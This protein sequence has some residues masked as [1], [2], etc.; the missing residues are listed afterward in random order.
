MQLDNKPQYNN[1][2]CEALIRL[3][4]CEY[5]NSSND[6]IPLRKAWLLLRYR[7]KMSYS[8]LSSCLS[9]IKYLCQ[10]SIGILSCMMR[11][12]HEQAGQRTAIH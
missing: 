5:S 1:E 6:V 12:F 3:N 11:I 8:G 10:I 9:R 7:A 2:G 4:D